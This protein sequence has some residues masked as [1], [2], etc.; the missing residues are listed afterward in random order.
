[1]DYLL[2]RPQFLAYIGQGNSRRVLAH[3]EMAH[4]LSVGIH[5]TTW[6]INRWRGRDL[7]VNAVRVCMLFHADVVRSH[8]VGA[9]TANEE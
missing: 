5:S 9:V 7:P 6:R 2:S 4:V 8:P 1:M 3:T